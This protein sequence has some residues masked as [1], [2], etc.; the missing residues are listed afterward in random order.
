MLAYMVQI[1]LG[2]PASRSHLGHRGSAHAPAGGGLGEPGAWV[3]NI[4]V[5]IYIYICKYFYISISDIYIY[6]P[7]VYLYIYMYACIYIYIHRCTS[8]DVYV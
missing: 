5:D 8:T 7:A 2:P 6:I 3:R 1:M 4:H